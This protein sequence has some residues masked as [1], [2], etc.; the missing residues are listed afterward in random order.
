MLFAFAALFLAIY[1]LPT[2]VALARSHPSALAIFVLNLLLGGTGVFWVW[3]L[4]WALSNSSSS[5]TPNITIINQVSAGP[6]MN[7]VSA[8]LPYV[9]GSAPALGGVTRDTRLEPIS[10]EVRIEKF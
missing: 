4:V 10:R 3:S 9:A 1:L 2:I 8:A 6:A 7:H 5:R